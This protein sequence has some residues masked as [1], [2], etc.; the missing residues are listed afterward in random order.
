MI[1]Y[2][3]RRRTVNPR[4]GDKVWIEGK[5]PDQPMKQG[6]NGFIAVINYEEQECVIVLEGK[7]VT[8]DLDELRDCWCDAL[9]SY[10]VEE[11]YREINNSNTPSGGDV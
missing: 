7:Q 4:R 9:D 2:V 1:Q 10:I 3:T 5:V 6:S 11:P 8:M